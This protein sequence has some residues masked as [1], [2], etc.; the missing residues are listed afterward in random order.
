M[1]FFLEIVIFAVSVAKVYS[2]YVQCS[3]F[4]TMPGP[5]NDIGY[6]GSSTAGNYS[7]LQ[8]YCNTSIYPGS[9]RPYVTSQVIVQF[10]CDPPISDYIWLPLVQRDNQALSTTGWMWENGTEEI[11][12]GAPWS[13]Q[14]PND[15]PA[16]DKAED[17]SENC[18]VLACRTGGVNDYNCNQSDG[19]A[20][21]QIKCKLS[22]RH[23]V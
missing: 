15:A 3:E 16:S 4:K 22:F 9:T 11:D 5:G 2:S 17:N 7:F 6:Y 13:S 20:F 18:G 19:L 8:N 21:C 14:E 12:L 1:I 23:F 10:L